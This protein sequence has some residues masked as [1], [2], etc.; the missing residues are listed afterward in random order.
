MATVHIVCVDCGG[1][2]TIY[3]DDSRLEVVSCG[4]CAAREKRLAYQKGWADGLKNYLRE[5]ENANATDNES[6]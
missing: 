2:L 4:I 3:Y 5:E 1:S 6:A